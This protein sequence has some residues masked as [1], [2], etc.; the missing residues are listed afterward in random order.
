[1]PQI[2]IAAHSEHTDRLAQYAKAVVDKL[3][4]ICKPTI[5]VGGYWGIMRDVVDEALNKGLTVVIV[6]PLEKEDVEYPAKTIVIKTGCSFRCRSN[7]LVRSSDALIVLGGGV[8]TIIEAVT[9]YAEG[10]PIHVLL[11]GMPS[12]KMQLAW[13]EYIDDRQIVR[14]MYH[15]DPSEA[16]KAACESASGRRRAAGG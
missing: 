12:D 16:A 6:A 10:I 4:E 3:A 9:A 7:I 15:R 8:G 1:M 11:S 5:L 14:L 2:G 13:P